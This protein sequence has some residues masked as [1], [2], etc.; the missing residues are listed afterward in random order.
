MDIGKWTISGAKVIQY[1]CV[2][3]LELKFS[4]PVVSFAFVDTDMNA[5]LKAHGLSN[6]AAGTVLSF[7]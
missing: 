4:S 6:L 5:E 1:F 7:F 3:C 2:L